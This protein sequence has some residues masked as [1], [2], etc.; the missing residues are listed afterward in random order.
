MAADNFLE[1]F[2]LGASVYDRAQTQKRMT[3]QLQ[4]QSNQQLMQQNSSDLLNKIHENALG[5][6]LKEL[7]ARPKEFSKLPTLTQES[8]TSRVG[9][10]SV[11]FV[12]PTWTLL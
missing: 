3:E 11:F 6:S 8:Y 1:G 12:R 10:G 2:Q 5:Q 9:G 7:E 4:W